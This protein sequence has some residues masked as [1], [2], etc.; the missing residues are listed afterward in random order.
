VLVGRLLPDQPEALG[1]L[2]LMRLHLARAEARFEGGRLVLLADQDRS[3]WD[4][5]G[6]AAAA[7]LVVRA[8]KMGRPGPYQ[9]QAAIAACHAEARS[10]AET[11]WPQIVL[12]YGRLLRL[13]PSPV[14]RLNRAIATSHVRGPQASL[15]EVEALAH[16]LGRYH[17]YHATRAALLRRLDRPHEARA[18][19]LAA[20]ELTANPA[21]RALLEDRLFNRID[22]EE[23]KP[24]A[25]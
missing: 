15:A 19:D 5:A 17:L 16:E 3:R 18:A 7:E 1:L 25:K 24:N 4:G 11:D 6:I 9:V 14:V 21:E 12:L 2:A 23:V 20:L 22:H 8:L 10:W 13:A